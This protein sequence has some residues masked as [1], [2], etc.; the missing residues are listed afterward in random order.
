MTLQV[1]DFRQNIFLKDNLFIK[2]ENVMAFSDVTATKSTA[3]PSTSI[4]ICFVYLTKGAN[5]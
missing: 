5:P 3:V 2:K 4:V 1:E